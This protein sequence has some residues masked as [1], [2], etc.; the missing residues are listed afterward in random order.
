MTEKE[1]EKFQ[2]SDP[3]W[4]CKKLIDDKK[5]RDHCHSTWNFRG[6]VHWSCNINLQ[7]TKKDPVMFHNLRGHDS[8]N[9]GIFKLEIAPLKKLL[10]VTA[11]LS[12]F[13]NMELSSTE[14]I[15][16]DLAFFLTAVVWYNSKKTYCQ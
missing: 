16:L 1:E 8:T 4:I 5:V 6:A 10:K 3:F 2:S 7:L 12:L 14:V 15:L 11:I 9:G 13:S